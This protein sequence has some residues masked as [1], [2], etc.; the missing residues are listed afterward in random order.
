MYS[1][2]KRAP[3]QLAWRIPLHGELGREVCSFLGT[4]PR[5]VWTASVFVSECV[6]RVCIS[7][8]G[9]VVWAVILPVQRFQI[10]MHNDYVIDTFILRLIDD[11]W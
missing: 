2:V 3:G 10:L 4:S 7:Y 5:G 8:E 1:K 11:E 6:G 9:F